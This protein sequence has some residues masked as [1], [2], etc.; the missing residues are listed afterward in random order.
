MDAKAKRRVWDVCDDDDRRLLSLNRALPNQLE[1]CVN[2]VIGT[3]NHLNIHENTEAIGSKDIR[4]I[5][6]HIIILQVVQ[7]SSVLLSSVLSLL[8]EDSLHLRFYARK[9]IISGK[10]RFPVNDPRVGRTSTRIAS[11]EVTKRLGQ[12]T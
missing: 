5:R 2:R 10:L 7:L 9:H 12:G 4:I 6:Q 8:F 11:P 1:K 3:E